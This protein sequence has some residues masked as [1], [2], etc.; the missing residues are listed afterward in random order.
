MSLEGKKTKATQRG[1]DEKLT[2]K[3]HKHVQVRTQ[4][5]Q[6]T[7]C[8]HT[9]VG[10]NPMTGQW[11]RIAQPGVYRPPQKRSSFRKKNQRVNGGCCGARK[12]TR[13]K[14]QESPRVKKKNKNKSLTKGAATFPV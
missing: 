11:E 3:G 2:I 8:N 4:S 7:V 13:G 5:H 12:S 9:L 14:K 1:G 10:S 6:G